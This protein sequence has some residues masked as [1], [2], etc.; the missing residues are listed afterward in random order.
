MTRSIVR[1]LACL[2]VHGADDPSPA[3]R[4][5]LIYEESRSFIDLILS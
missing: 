5:H 3:E 2:P 1:L 4:I